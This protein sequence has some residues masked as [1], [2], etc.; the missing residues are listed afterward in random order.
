MQPARGQDKGAAVMFLLIVARPPWKS[1]PPYLA[2][3]FRKTTKNSMVR[4]VL[5]KKR[6]RFSAVFCRVPAVE[7][8]DFCYKI[9]FSGA[10]PYRPLPGCRSRGFV[11]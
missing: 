8:Q 3:F 11:L 9:T 1:K 7:K 6:R 2:A 5:P 4:C 10:A